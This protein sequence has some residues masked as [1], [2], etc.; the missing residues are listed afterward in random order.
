VIAR[1]LLKFGLVDEVL[2]LVERCEG[3]VNT[4]LYD[5]LDE[6]EPDDFR[7]EEPE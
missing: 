7:N 1:V 3:T 6:V 5:L 4:L 2:D